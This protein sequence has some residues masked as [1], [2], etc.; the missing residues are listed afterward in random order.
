MIHLSRTL[1]ERWKLKLKICSSIRHLSW[2]PSKLINQEKSWGNETPIPKGTNVATR[3][4]VIS[5]TCCFYVKMMFVNLLFQF[6]VCQLSAASIWCFVNL[7]PHQFAV[8][9]TFRHINLLFC[10]L[11]ITSICYFVYC[12]P[13][14]FAILSTFCHINLLFC[15]ISV[16]SICCLINFLPCQF[17]I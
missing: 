17:A 11:S 9:S 8:L 7:L 10:Q 3:S 2:L 5:S 13:H 4:Y 14:Q 15:Q 12:P 6:A 1:L 16:I